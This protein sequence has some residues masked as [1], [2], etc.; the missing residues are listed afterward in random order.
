MKL[1]DNKIYRLII[2][3]I[4]IALCFFGRFIPGPEGLSSD[5]MGVISIFIGSLILWL[6]IGIDWP[7]L[8]CIFALAFLENI[9]FNSALSKS[10]GNATFIFLLFTFICTYALSKTSLIRRVAIWFISTKLAKKSGN[11]FIALFL[12]AVLVLGLFISPSVLFVIIFPILNEVFAI[13]GIEKDDKVAKVLMMGLGFTVS[14]SS[15]MTPIAH[16]FPVLAM[17]AANVNVSPLAYMGMAIPVGLITF[18]LMLLAFRFI[19]RPDVSKLSNVD[20]STLS[21]DS[22]SV[23]NETEQSSKITKKEIAILSIFAFVILLWIVPSFFKDGAPEFYDAINKYG[24]AMP[25]ILGVLLLC[26][27]KF[28]GKPIITLDDA[29]KN[30][31]PWTALMMCAATLVLG[32]ALTDNA[33]GIKAFL[34][35]NLSSSLSSL[36]AIALL[37]IFAFWAALQTNL[38]SNMVTAT[39]VSTVAASILIATSS[40]LSV[41]A[42]A[43]IIGMLASFAFAT[44]P[45]MPHIAI[46]AGSDYCD[47]KD[48]LIYGSLLMVI[49][50][51]IALVI[52]YPLGSILM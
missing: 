1:K 6:T 8:L 7:S 37:I 14:I 28:D 42:V 16:V 40:T 38:S 9:G 26:I 35:N 5:A 44:P 12:L 13:A 20:T 23:S 46:V 41:P 15:G 25:P 30:G 4:C 33:I 21:K 19:V 29:F 51:V 2:I 50:V 24:T 43:S 47:T 22:V 52:G 27:I 31:V 48:V 36:P 11:W 49:S 45:S 3:P 17:N 34:Q 10:F 32:A 18:V 39:L